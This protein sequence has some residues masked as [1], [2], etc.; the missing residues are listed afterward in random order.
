MRLP[1]RHVHTDVY[2]DVYADGYVDVFTGVS[3]EI[4]RVQAVALRF[5]GLPPQI[6][7]K[8]GSFFT[9]AQVSPLTAVSLFG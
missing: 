7:A 2:A 6:A 3:N 5:A 4:R 1:M 8:V 9:V